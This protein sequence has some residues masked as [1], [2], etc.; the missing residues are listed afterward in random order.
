MEEND[1]TS[2]KHLLHAYRRQPWWVLLLIA[3]IPPTGAA[4]ISSYFTYR[5]A[6]VEAKGKAAEAKYTAE[7][8]YEELVKAVNLLQSHDTETVKAIAELNGHVK[9]IESLM[10]SGKPHRDAV[11]HETHVDLPAHPKFPPPVAAPK[12][13]Q[14]HVD[15]PKSLDDA[16]KK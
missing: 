12:A 8:G 14:Q 15:L 13:A 3:V 7:K 16:A 6:V 10:T 4:L 1:Q 11:T 2:P 9:A 5:A